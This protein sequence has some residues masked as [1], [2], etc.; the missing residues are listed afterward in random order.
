MNL[1]LITERVLVTGGA[2][3]IPE[4]PLAYAKRGHVVFYLSCSHELPDAL[5]GE[6]P[7]YLHEKIVFYG[8]RLPWKS[9]FNRP[10]RWLV[11]LKRAL[12][13]PLFLW[14]AMLIVLELLHNN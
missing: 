1:L 2:Q 11:P 14:K 10:S 3:V 9:L 13:L 12:F 6:H 5:V 7:G 4:T 8:I